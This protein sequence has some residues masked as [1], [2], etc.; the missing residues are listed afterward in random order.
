M[1]AC[2]AISRAGGSAYE[3][4]DP[5][6]TAA[7]Y[8]EL[9]EP[10]IAHVSNRDQPLPTEEECEIDPPLVKRPAGR[11]RNKRIESQKKISR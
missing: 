2:V 9:Y 8:R 6:Y 4:V 10:A 7:K 3:F 1:H 5:C 11:P